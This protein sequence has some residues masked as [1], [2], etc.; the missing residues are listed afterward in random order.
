MV[1][2]YGFDGLRVDSAKHVEKGFW[3]GFESAA[4]VFVTGEVFNGDPNYVAPFQ[5][6]MS[7]LLNYPAYYWITQAFQSSAA[8]ITRLAD[9]IN[10]LRSQAKDL[11]L[12]GSFLENHDQRRFP[13]LTSDAALVKNAISF[14]LLMDGIPIIYQGQEQGYNGSDVPYNREALWLSGYNIHSQLYGWISVLLRLRSSAIALDEAYL[15]YQ[16]W[17]IYVN[18]HLIAMRKGFNGNQIIGIY[19]NIGGK[20]SYSLELPS[21][22][23]GF[24]VGED[25][26]DVM[27]CKL[28][29]PDADGILRISSPTG[30]PTILY[31][32]RALAKMG[33][34]AESTNVFLRPSNL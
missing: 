11:N 12:Y 19:T 32:A 30:E 23:T 25:V 29:K 31:P 2:K 13:S 17:P 9:G 10:K 3:P 18:D 7:G 26:L 22:T 1:S 28:V 27:R 6:Y 33:F 21:A 4:G 24:A 8:N 14:T 20:K 15:S 34:C 5:G 16:A